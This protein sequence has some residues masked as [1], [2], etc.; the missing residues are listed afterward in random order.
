MLYNKLSYKNTGELYLAA[1]LTEVL[2][3]LTDLH[4]LDLLPQTGTI[5]GT[6]VLGETGDYS[7]TSLEKLMTKYAPSNILRKK[8]KRKTF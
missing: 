3:V 7:R 4:L 5:T 8:R 6:Y 2:A 1:E